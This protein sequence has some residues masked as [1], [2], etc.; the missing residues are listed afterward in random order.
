N[1]DLVARAK[2]DAR[3]VEALAVDEHVAMADEL[4]RLR[5]RERE[6]EAVHDAVEPRLEE[7]EHLL[8]GAALT[9]R[10]AEVVLLELALD[11]AVDAPHLLLLA[12][13][14]RVL[15][16]L[17][18]RLPVLP[19]RIG[20]AGVRALLGVAAL[21]LQEELRALAAAK[22]ANRTMITSHEIF[23]CLLGSAAQTRRRLGGRHP[24]CGTGVTSRIRVTLKPTP[25]SARRALSRPAPGPFTKTA[26][27]RTP[28]SIALRAASSAASCAAKGVLL[29]EPLK[30]REPALDQATVFPFT[31]VMVTTVLLNVDWM[32]AIPVEMFF[33]AFFLALLALPPDAPPGPGGLLV[34]VWDMNAARSWGRERYG[35]ATG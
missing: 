7:A 12:Q 6:P 3:D 28:C 18:A 30:P 31:S 15:A 29:R 20:P 2:D 17:D 22:L 33:F 32:W 9:A 10:G 5:A 16:Q 4:A 19:R 25:W 11:D 14:D 23:S 27:E 24:L 26:T 8:A 34:F 21:T 13:A 1:F 35:F